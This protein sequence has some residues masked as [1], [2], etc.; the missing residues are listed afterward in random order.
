MLPPDVRRANAANEPYVTQIG[1]GV[2]LFTGL[3]IVAFVATAITCG[4]T[5]EMAAATLFAAE[6]ELF[7]VWPSPPAATRAAVRRTRP[8]GTAS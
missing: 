1:R 7:E 5:G 6:H 2:G 3:F 8:L 4:D